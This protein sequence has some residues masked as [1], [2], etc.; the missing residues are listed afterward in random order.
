MLQM[1]RR[2]NNWYSDFWYKGERYVK[3]HGP[4]SKTIGK[5]KDRAFRAE[6]AAGTYLKNKNNPIF[7]QAIEE[8]LKKSQAENEASSYRRNLISARHLKAHFGNRRVSTIEGNQ[9]LMRQY[10]KKRKEQIKAKQM[11]GGRTEAEVTYTSIN[12]ELA[13]L[14]S[15]FNVLIKAS[16][17]RKNPVSLVTLF[18][19]IQKERILTYDEEDQIVEAIEKSDK[20]YDHLKN[21]VVIA[22]NTGMREGEILNMEKSWIDPKISLIVVPR[23]AQKRKRKDK[24]VPINSAIRPIIKR[25]LK[26]DI[27]SEYLFVNPKTKTRYTKIQNSW[28]TILKKA[29]LKGKPGVDRLR[30]HD[31]RHTAATN[32]A[33]SGND[34]KFIAQY[35]GHMDVK[36]S[37]RY[38]HYSDK[39]LKEGAETLVRLPSKITTLKIQSQQI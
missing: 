9:I 36:T 10:I 12:R 2:H 21:M 20:R 29:G 6:V 11:D 28:T 32:L 23:Q 25:L 37:A 13:L 19:E 38:I 34:M 15:M 33:R 4:V 16:K 3:S 27:D 39:D 5:E 22:L 24:R 35:L 14:R 18:E 8:H 7:T 30:F 17:A 31:L 26:K 1:Y